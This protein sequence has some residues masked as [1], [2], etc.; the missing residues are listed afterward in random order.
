MRWATG[1][2]AAEAD[3]RESPAGV[4]QLVSWGGRQLRN[5]GPGRERKETW[6][7]TVVIPTWVGLRQRVAHVRSGHSVTALGQRAVTNLAAGEL[8]LHEVVRAK[9]PT[10]AV[11][12]PETELPRPS[13]SSRF[14]PATSSCGDRLVERDP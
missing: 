7:V 12:A 9:P 14:D 4:P 1:I 11:C 8:A 13:E 3:G 10:D 5:S 6:E 2:V